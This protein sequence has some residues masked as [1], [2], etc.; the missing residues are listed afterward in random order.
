MGENLGFLKE[1]DLGEIGDGERL[2]FKPSFLS[3]Q[4]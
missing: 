4:V 2:V 1:I 3:V